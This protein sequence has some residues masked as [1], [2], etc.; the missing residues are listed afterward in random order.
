MVGTPLPGALAALLGVCSH[1]AG[2][3]LNPMGVPIAW[4]VTDRHYRV[5]DRDGDSEEERGV[6]WAGNELANWLL[7]ALGTVLALLAIG[8]A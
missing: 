1:L 4:P 5:F 8:A 7:L 3:A 6:C 2:D